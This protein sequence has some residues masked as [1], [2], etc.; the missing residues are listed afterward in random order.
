MARLP[1]LKRF[2]AR[3]D[4]KIIG[5][6]QLIAYRIQQERLVQRAAEITMATRWGN[7]RVVAYHSDIDPD[8]HAALV[9][10]DITTPEPVLVRMH[11]QCVTGDV[12]HS[13]RCDCGEQVELALDRIVEEGR[14]VFV[15]MRQEGRGIGFCNKIRAYALQDSQG[16]DTV[17]A[18]EALGFP[19]DRRDYGIGMQILV[20]LGLREIR[21]LTNN[22]DK[23]AGLEGYGLKVL[24]RVPLVARPTPTTCATWRPSATSWA[25]CWTSWAEE[26]ALATFEGRQSGQGLSIAI[27][28]SRFNELVTRALL[29][30]AQ[31]GLASHGVE[32][33]GV[34]VAWVPGSFE[35]PLTARKLAESGRYQ[36]VVCVGAVIRGETPHFDQVANQASSGIARVALDTGV[37][38]IF[39][40]I[41]A[42]TL[43][44]A[45]E[46]AGG[47]MGN[48]GYDAAVA[49]IEMANLMRGLRP[50]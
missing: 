27:V 34:D 41:T 22:P 21:L 43:E 46:R 20:D 13:L 8:E 3:H 17:E 26:G 50:D 45:L 48:K 12:F 23:R 49:A 10:G 29:S 38:V 5:I 16:L 33:E 39:G 19:A 7:F 37:P 9:F 25:T 35:I 18:N 11:S 1:D 36:A 24:E 44:Q 28:V 47:K 15:Y 2:A 30:G 32:P 42:D 6:N 4:M 14:G 40:I 31:D